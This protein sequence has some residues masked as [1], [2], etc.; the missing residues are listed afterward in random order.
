MKYAGII[1]ND[2]ANGPGI[3]VSFFTQGCPHHCKGCFNPETWDPEGGKEFT[4]DT[5]EEIKTALV[6]NGIKR[7]LSILGGE[8][9]CPDNLFLTE[10]LIREI[11]QTYP[12]ITIYLW[13]GYKYSELSQSTNKSIQYILSTIDTLIDGPFIEEQRDITLP[14][15]GSRNQQIIDLKKKL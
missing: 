2:I 6:A 4:P 14:L 15:R 1:K 5:L 11:K 8:P 12:D 9:L 7:N 13:T 10:L 3:R